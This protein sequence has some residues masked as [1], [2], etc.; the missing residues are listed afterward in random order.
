MFGRD[1]SDLAGLAR[2]YVGAA[3]AY[4][5][6]ET[7]LIRALDALAAAREGDCPG[8]ITR[9]RQA[10]I[11]AD[12]AAGIAWD[13]AEVARRAF[14]RQRAAE[15]EAR[16][17]AECVPMLVQLS[18]YQRFAGLSAIP[19]EHLLR[20]HLIAPQAHI[21]PEGDVRIEP[22]DSP[23]LDRANDEIIAPQSGW[24]MPARKT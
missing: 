14:W 21:E 17:V 13:E 22:L 10:A 5:N 4:K 20:H 3:K 9:T 1:S 19:P 24:K 7:A 2:A 8:D 12:K 6:A 11:E 23:A 15:H 18:A 16:V